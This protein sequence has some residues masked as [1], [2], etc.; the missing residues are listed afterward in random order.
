M[1]WTWCA[2]WYVWTEMTLCNMP[3]DNVL[4]WCFL[5]V[6]IKVIC[7]TIG[8]MRHDC[9][10][11]GTDTQS[12][13][14]GDLD[15]WSLYTGQSFTWNRGWSLGLPWCL[16][17]EHWKQWGL[18]WETNR[19]GQSERPASTRLTGHKMFW[20]TMEV[21]KWR[22][23]KDEPV[24]LTRHASS[25]SFQQRF[26]CFWMSLST[27]CPVITWGQTEGTKA[28]LFLF[29]LFRRYLRFLFSA[30]D[31][32]RAAAESCWP[33][34]RA[35]GPSGRRSWSRSPEGPDAAVWG[36]LQWIQ[37]RRQLLHG[38]V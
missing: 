25:K 10:S 9:L 3:W 1:N 34:A 7:E 21:S 35:T 12:K 4:N 38:K 6:F 20:E 32:G 17:E 31:P 23:S 36:S 8:T 27:D 13:A 30:P 33:S 19:P 2:V 14:G 22:S 37:P 18:S 15:Q 29:F 26:S 16:R 24:T 5:F 28:F 11:F